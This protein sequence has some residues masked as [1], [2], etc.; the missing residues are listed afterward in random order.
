MKK[1]NS[2]KS[3][4]CQKVTLSELARTFLFIGV[5]SVGGGLTA[6]VRRIIVENKKWMTD[7]QFFPGLA[8]C[9]LLPGANVVGLALYIGNYLCGTLGAFVATVALITPPAFILF[10]LGY[11]YFSHGALPSVNAV[12]IGVA[13]VA[14]GLMTSMFVQSARVSLRNIFD[15]MVFLTTFFL[16]KFAHVRVPYAILMMAPIAI[17]WYRPKRSQNKEVEK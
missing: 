10:G 6:Y 7:E 9:Q 17:W 13:A 11:F 4:Q 14:C 1:N 5:T 2:P 12:L 3:R 16:V 8:L 15:V